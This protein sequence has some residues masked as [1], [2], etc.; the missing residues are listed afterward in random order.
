MIKR[1]FDAYYM[2]PYDADY[3]RGD[4]AFYDAELVRTAYG[5]AGVTLGSYRRVD[6]PTAGGRP[7]SR[8][9]VTP[10][11]LAGDRK[12]RLVHTTFSRR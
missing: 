12:L 3:A 11:S 5:D 8:T 2:R 4:T 7:R 6:L 1:I 9:I 10:G